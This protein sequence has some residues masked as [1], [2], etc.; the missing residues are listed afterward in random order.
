MKTILVIRKTDEFSRIL[1]QNGFEV[2]NLPTIETTP[3]EDLSDLETKLVR[4]EDYDGIFITSQ[5]AA[6]ILAEKIDELNVNFAGEIYVLG[7]SSFEILKSKDFNLVF[8]EDANTAAEMLEKISPDELNNKYFLFVRGE[9][10][11]ETIPNFLAEI[12]VCDETIVYRNQ[13]IALDSD[14]ISKIT[15]SFE[16]SMIEA[17]CFFSPSGAESFISEFGTEFLHQTKIAAI[18]KTTADFFEKRNLKIDF[19]SPKATAKDFAE[20]L[21]KYLKNGKWK[22]EN[23]K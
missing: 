12:A 23:G 15:V 9:K 1:H 17:V 20:S 11:L 21:I 16:S 13:P 5:P 19:V 4:I 7:K 14:S 2:I 3:L 10:S 18:G 22:M 8:F 6:R